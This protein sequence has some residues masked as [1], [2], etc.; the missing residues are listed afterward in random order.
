MYEI[1]ITSDDASWANSLEENIHEK[2]GQ[3]ELFPKLETTLAPTESYGSPV[4][5]M[6]QVVMKGFEEE[7][8]C[9]LRVL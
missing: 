9:T 8:H 4:R 7:F 6:F 5:K 1:P 3:R 2:R